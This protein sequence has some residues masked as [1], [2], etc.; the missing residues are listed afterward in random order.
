MTRIV[1][2]DGLISSL[3]D[4]WLFIDTSSLVAAF[5]YKDEFSTLFKDLSDKNCTFLTIPSVLFEFT[6]GS[7]TRKVFNTRTEFVTDLTNLY[8]I[9]RH[10]DKLEQQIILIQKLAP[11]TSHT[12]FLLIMCLLKFPPAHLLTENHKDMPLAIL[13]RIHIIT[14]DTD[15][16]IRNQAIYQ[17]NQQKYRRQLAKLT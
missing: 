17:L 12:D 9:D 8:P 4:A 6:R 15:N 2:S 3:K 1:S 11:R 10:L 14:I 13:D 7:D 5:N 16:Q